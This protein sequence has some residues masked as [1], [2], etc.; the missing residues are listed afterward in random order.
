MSVLFRR[1]AVAGLQLVVAASLCGALT[2]WGA[3]LQVRW[4]NDLVCGGKKLGGV[5]A[6]ARTQASGGY[7]VLGL[8]VNVSCDLTLFPPD[9]R[10]QST[11]LAAESAEPVTLAQAE[12]VALAALQSDLDLFFG[13]GLGPFL[14]ILE[15]NSEVKGRRVLLHYADGSITGTV[16]GFADNGGLVLEDGSLHLAPQK[17]E[18]I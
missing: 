12:E 10:G 4:P 14:G 7:C 16:S 11:T 13:Q 8:G 6:E 1:P 9:L 18:L 15:A 2:R 3:P 5:L 17:L